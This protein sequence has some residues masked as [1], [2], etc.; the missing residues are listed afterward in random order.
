MNPVAIEPLGDRPDCALALRKELPR[1][2][3]A[4]RGR[5]RWPE[6]EAW[7]GAVSKNGESDGVI[8]GLERF[9]LE[10]FEISPL[11]QMKLP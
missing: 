4:P 5:P 1:D 7:T 8:Q 3:S 10:F 11:I 6:L 2:F 9:T